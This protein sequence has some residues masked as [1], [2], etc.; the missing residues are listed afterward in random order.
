LTTTWARN[1]HRWVRGREESLVLGLGGAQLESVAA[2]SVG[3]VPVDDSSSTSQL[4]S[5]WSR[6]D[7]RCT[8]TVSAG[9]AG[10][11]VEKG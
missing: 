4:T 3:S 8:G 1:W 9:G 7:N 11:E 6:A 10:V 5:T 2:H